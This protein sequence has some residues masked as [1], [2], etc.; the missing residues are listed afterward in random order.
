L[1]GAATLIDTL[2]EIGGRTRGGARSNVASVEM[3][4][5]HLDQR[6]ICCAA[7]KVGA[8]AE[9][10]DG[11]QRFDTGASRDETAGYRRRWISIVILSGAEGS[12]GVS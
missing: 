2:N 1:G 12:R 9:S 7:V 4:N 5:R 8:V 3:R 10:E 6:I 11:T